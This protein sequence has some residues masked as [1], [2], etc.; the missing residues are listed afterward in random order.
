MRSRQ[1]KSTNPYAAAI[2]NKYVETKEFNELQLDVE[3]LAAVTAVSIG[4]A[5]VPVARTNNPIIGANDVNDNISALDTAIGT[6]AQLTPAV[7][8]VGA[9]VADTTVHQKVEALDTAIGANV[10]AYTRTTGQIA[11]NLAVNQNINNLDTAI[12][13]DAHMTPVGR[14][15]GPIAVAN[16]VYTNLDALDSAIGY[17]A[18]M[19]GTGKDVSKSAYTV[20]QNIDRLD[21]YKSVRTIKKTIG[22]VGVVGCDFNFAT[23]GDVDQQVI[24]L[25]AL[26]P[27][28]GWVMNVFTRTDAVF[29]GATTLVAEIGTTSSG[30]QLMLE[31]SMYATDAI[32]MSDTTAISLTAPVVAATNVY[33]AATPGANWSNVT[34]GKVSVYITLVDVRNI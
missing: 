8:T 33:F 27:S 30:N 6:D 15:V 24:D 28:L 34:A 17:D 9:V 1:I 11:T 26:I 5:P 31:T 3:E 2:N 25:G 20:Y 21:T 16:T 22:G 32:V 4:A 19:S 12:G 14:T 7:R 29:T 13:A 10:N 23:A 18:Q